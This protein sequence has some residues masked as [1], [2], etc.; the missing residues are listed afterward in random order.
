MSFPRF[1]RIVTVRNRIATHIWICC[2]S[3]WLWNVGTAQAVRAQKG[4]EKLSQKD[5]NY[6]AELMAVAQNGEGK[7]MLLALAE[8][9][10]WMAICDPELGMSHLRQAESL[11]PESRDKRN[12]TYLMWAMGSYYER[13]PGA[14]VEHVKKAKTYADSAL[15]LYQKYPGDSILL[16]D[17]YFLIG[18]LEH[19]LGRHSL[20][21]KNLLSCIE[22]LRAKEEK[23]HTLEVLKRVGEVYYYLGEYDNALSY[24]NQALSVAKKIKNVWMIR[25]LD[26]DIGLIHE[27][28]GSYEEALRYYRYAMELIDKENEDVQIL[29][30]GKSVYLS[31]TGSVYLKMNRLDSALHYFKLGYEIRKKLGLPH[32]EVRS[33]VNVARVYSAMN[34]REAAKRQFQTALALANTVS[35]EG[36]WIYPLYEA[37][38]FFSNIGQSDTAIY[39]L[40][41]GLEI[42]Q[43]RKERDLEKQF[44][45]ALADAHA[46][47]GLTATALHYYKLFSTLKDTLYNEA[48]QRNLMDLNAKYDV[49]LH[50]EKAEASK[51]QNELNVQRLKVQRWITFSA[52]V[53][54]LTMMTAVF[55][56]FRARNRLRRSNE[57]LQKQNH[58]I[59]RQREQIKMQADGLKEQGDRLKQA[60]E[61]LQMLGKFKESMI[62]MAAHDLKNP[63]NSLLVSSECIEDEQTKK[64][65]QVSV[66]RMLNLILT[67][68]DVQKH[69]N[70]K[71]QLACSDFPI[72]KAIRDA[73][74]QTAYLLEAK[75]IHFS[76]GESVGYA[77]CADYELYV[78]VLVN[79]LTNAAKYTP[80]NGKITIEARKCEDG[81]LALSVR[82]TGEGIPE[83]KLE[84]VF[85][86]YAQA[87]A[88]DLG[89]TRS[90]GM[91]LYFCKAVVE[92]HGGNIRVESE[93]GKGTMFEFTVPLL[94]NDTSN[95]ADDEFV[96]DSFIQISIDAITIPQEYVEVLVKCK[97]YEASKILSVIDAIEGYETWKK[98]IKNAVFSCNEEKYNR[99]IQNILPISAA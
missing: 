87:D 6:Y 90:T 55:L 72:L 49:A 10:Q 54:L 28:L 69:E 43:K 13:L 92:E 34:A 3:G 62:G 95:K 81:M 48:K 26:N 96:L 63:L 41:K 30:E 33:L 36:E 50:R 77:V 22:I 5:K 64:I 71:L 4:W 99:L 68:L 47:M 76:T 65:I 17:I 85:E 16:A 39:L 66:R 46:K 57:L 83:D 88:K 94:S 73:H 97:V 86:L 15:F 18:L 84:T 35:N 44:Y 42:A 58:E 52:I 45:E 1:R 59:S 2:F 25:A 29:Q 11:I 75:N 24:Y 31:N 32:L 67:M 19:Q 61:S 78:R 7:E 51:L 27:K 8:A 70:A 21:I 9:G 98:E 60:Y 53:V 82:D 91:G 89:I 56:L 20:G 74:Q 12:L 93:V 37:G 79:L 80:F 40:K 38:K 14:E 23:S